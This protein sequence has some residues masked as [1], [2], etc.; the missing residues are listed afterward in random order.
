MTDFTISGDPAALRASASSLRALAIRLE[1]TATS[2]RRLSTYGWEGVAADAFRDA[3][4]PEPRR[5]EQAADGFRDA[6]SALDAHAGTLEWAKTRAVA[7]AEAC[8]AADAVTDQ[9]RRAHEADRAFRP[10]PAYGRS[11]LEAAGAF[12]D[13]GAA[14]R[15]AALE[16]FRAIGNEVE[17]SG[18]RAAA[19]VR[20]ACDAAP[21]K[22]GWFSRTVGSFFLGAGES[23][24][25]LGRMALWDLNPQ[26]QLAWAA[27]RVATGQAT[28]GEIADE[29]ESKGEALAAIAQA[30]YQDPDGFALNVGKSLID[31]ETWQDDPAR[32]LGH[33]VPDAVAAVASGGAGAGAKALRSLDGIHD[34]AM[35]ERPLHGLRTLRGTNALD[36]AGLGNLDDVSLAR[37]LDEIGPSGQSLLLRRGEDYEMRSMAGIFEKSRETHYAAHLDSFAGTPG[38]VADRVVDGGPLVNYHASAAP[39]SGA[40]WTDPAEMLRMRSE[41]DAFDRLALRDEWDMRF[42]DGT[43][44]QLSRDEI[45]VREFAVGEEQRM[46]TGTVGPQDRAQPRAWEANAEAYRGAYRDD[47]GPTHRLDGTPIP[48]TRPGGGVQHI[49]GR[50]PGAYSAE[51]PTWSGPPPWVERADGDWGGFAAGAAAGVA[52]TSGAETISNAEQVR[53]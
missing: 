52:V 4:T 3:F 5:W 48:E 27:V 51:V 28:V 14:A 21:S 29:F 16:D 24:W 40:F 23:L 9:A 41:Q 1:T 42:E 31:L 53:P 25:D 36:L 50:E 35:W 49:A 2:M 46:Q 6:A 12:T 30:A 33:L 38:S 7:C 13:P 20:A 17:D 15:N 43:W 11:L 37:H 45:T 8:R 32:A 44:H 18:D 26:T 10:Q 22:P 34:V 39:G 47:V 19:R